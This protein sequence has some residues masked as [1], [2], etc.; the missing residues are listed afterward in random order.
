MSL[1]SLHIA[2]AKAAELLGI[3]ITNRE[4]GELQNKELYELG[5]IE[6]NGQKYPAFRAYTGPKDKIGKGGIRFALYPSRE[7]GIEV[8]QELSGEMY[9]KMLLRRHHKQFRGAKGLVIVDVWK[10][11]PEEKLEVSRQYEALMEKA[12]LV[13]YNKDVPAGDVGTNGLS[14]SYA[15]AYA[16]N[17]PDDRYKSAVI[18]GKSPANGGLKARTSATGL[19]AFVSLKTVMEARGQKTTTVAIQAFGN[20]GSWFAY[21]ACA[22]FDK[23]IR[24]QAISERDGVLWTND[25]EGLPI[26]REMVEQIGDNISW[27]GPKLH[28]LADMIKKEKPGIHLEIDDDSSHIL[29]FEADYFVPAA[30]GDVITIDAVETLGARVGVLEIANGPTTAEAHEYL[31]ASGKIVIP[32]FLANS[33]GVDT[34]IYEWQTNVDLAEGKITR[35][36]DD[37]EVDAYQ[38]RSTAEVTREVLEMAQRLETPDLRIAAAAVTLTRLYDDEPTDTTRR[39]KRQLPLSSLERAGEPE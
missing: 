4:F 16:Q 8:V 30:M 19:G 20:A 36:P 23:S 2:Q 37:V 29:T 14:D 28:S 32:D 27:N 22:D 31:V 10:L 13:G 7:A 9:A 39:E 18:T 34:S 33:G 5:D 25:P 38:R 3:D 11:S 24:I 12:G 6:L 15:G 35:M 17:H 1:Q 21:Y 26:T